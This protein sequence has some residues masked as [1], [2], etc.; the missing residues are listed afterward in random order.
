MS[1]DGPGFLGQAGHL[2]FKTFGRDDSISPLEAL[3]YL[4][5]DEHFIFSD[6]RDLF[7]MTRCSA[8][9]S[10]WDIAICARI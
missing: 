5:T 2:A 3:P 7:P 9:T 6:L 1:L 8:A 10:V 4:L